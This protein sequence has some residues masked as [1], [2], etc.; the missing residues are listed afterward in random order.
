[1]SDDVHW[2]SFDHHAD[3]GEK[4]YQC[5]CNPRRAY[6]KAGWVEHVL[7]VTGGDTA[8]AARADAD[9]LAAALRA[10]HEHGM[11]TTARAA[12]AAHDAARAKKGL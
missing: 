9:R 8:A 3:D 5:E 10:L 1:V 7:S 6:N 12:L 11:G 4:F 2:P